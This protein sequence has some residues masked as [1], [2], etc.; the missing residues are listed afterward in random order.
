MQDRKAGLTSCNRKHKLSMT[1]VHSSMLSVIWSNLKTR[2]KFHVLLLLSVVIMIAVLEVSAIFLIGPLLQIIFFNEISSSLNNTMVAVFT[3]SNVG[4][5]STFELLG[6]LFL[7]VYLVASGGRF[8][9]S[10]YQSKLGYLIG[11]DIGEQIH[12]G[13]LEMYYDHFLK[14]RKSDAITNLTVKLGQLVHGT[15][16]PIIN[17]VSALISIVMILIALLIID[18]AS[19]LVATLSISLPYFVFYLFLRTNIN[20]IGARINNLL[21]AQVRLIS[22]SFGAFK[23]IRLS[24]TTKFY[25][26]RFS[27]QQSELS[28]AS[29]MLNFATNSPKHVIETLAV[30]LLAFAIA[31]NMSNGVLDSDMITL[32]GVFVLAIQRLLPSLQAIFYSFASIKGS[33]ASVRDLSNELIQLKKSKSLLKTSCSHLRGA[34]GK[35]ILLRLNNVSYKYPGNDQPSLYNL[36]LTLNRGDVLGVAGASGVGKST[37]I[38]LISGLLEPCNGSRQ[39]FRRGEEKIVISYVSNEIFISDADVMSN[40]ALG[41]GHSQIDREK[42]EKA[43]KVAN[44]HQRVCQLSHGYSTVIGEDGGTLSSGERQRI[45]IARALYCEPDILILDEG[46]N[47]LDALNEQKILNQILEGY[48]AI[49]VV[50][51]THNSESLRHCTRLLRVLDNRTFV[52]S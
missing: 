5:M 43:A 13:Y 21:T 30:V 17:S 16:I 42:V 14:A 28:S 2:R 1:S 29:S 15:V 38:H 40:I 45:S 3:Y 22:E 25:F 8:I 19:T 10:Y 47:A 34:K 52:F 32:L 4:S 9:L 11:K 26:T 27:V 39:T 31:T 33:S 6:S 36:S 51:V 20:R 37:L 23:H 24:E 48:P 50:F 12:R 35:D 41:V 18:F 44:L 46:T 7:L 49:A